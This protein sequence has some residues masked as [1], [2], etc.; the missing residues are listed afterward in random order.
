MVILI[1]SF[2]ALFAPAPSQSSHAHGATKPDRE[3]VLKAC[4]AEFGP[5][6]DGQ[7][8]LFDVSRYYLL[9]AKF[10]DSGR[11]M[12][13]GVFPKHWFGD[14]HPE[15]NETSDAGELTF[16]EY[17]KLLW[18][19]EGIQSKGSLIRRA[20]WPVVKGTT[21]TRRDTYRSAVLATSDVVD[22]KRPKNAPRAIKSFVLYFTA[23]K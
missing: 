10:D 9:E 6:I 1:L 2:L 19:L 15:W 18:R 11:L 16:A 21:A 5:A 14:Q 3:T 8:N 17:S 7:N 13:L 20:K 22:S 12:Q 23:T 4:A